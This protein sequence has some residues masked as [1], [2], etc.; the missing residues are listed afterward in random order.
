MPN[1]S[2]I[3]SIENEVEIAVLVPNQNISTQII[4]NN[5]LINTSNQ[6]AFANNYKIGMQMAI[7]SLKKLI[8][9]MH[10]EISDSLDI[11]SLKNLDSTNLNSKFIIQPLVIENDSTNYLSI[12]TLQNENPIS[13]NYLGL[14]EE[15]EMRNGIITYLR[16]RSGNKILIYDKDKNETKDF[17]ESQITNLRTI[18]IN[19]KGVF[20]NQDLIDHLDAKNK[21]YVIIESSRDG[22]FLSATNTL[23]KELSN[24]DIELVVLN[25]KYIPEDNKVSSKR[26]HIL[27]LIYPS[28]FSPLFYNQEKVLLKNYSENTTQND[29]NEITYGFG[30]TYN[31]LYQIY[32]NDYVSLKEYRFI[33][34]GIPLEYD[35]TNLLFSNKTV[36]IYRFEEDSNTFLLE[37]Y[38][39]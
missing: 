36:Y 13:I 29:R 25:A 2:G 15:S 35:D 10:L 28:G 34:L 4:W 18:R 33:N 27:K 6:S 14:I 16:E 8:P 9:N 24:Y 5:E 3:V 30:M 31:A 32:F 17:V 23:L 20:T 1:T 26:F 7:D 21:N 22:V 38:K 12:S 19:N 37:T 39:P 11:N